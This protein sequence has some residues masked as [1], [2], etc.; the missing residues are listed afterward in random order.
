MGICYTFNSKIAQYLTVEYLLDG[1]MF[2][3]EEPYVVNFFDVRKFAL[4]NDLHACDVSS[5]N[6][7]LKS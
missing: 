7:K 4:I 3:N 5:G 1:I 6:W 2:E